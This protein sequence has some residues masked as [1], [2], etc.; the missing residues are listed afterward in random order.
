MVF[1][2]LAIGKLRDTAIRAA[3]DDYLGRARRYFRMEV[4][5]VTG[6]PRGTSPAERRRAEAAALLAGLSPD[7]TT[8]ALTRAGRSEDSAR[9][10]R[11]MATWQQ[12]GRDVTFLIGGAFGLD[13][14]VLARCDARISLSALT[15]PHE[16]ARLVL[17]EQLYRAA[18]ILNGEPYHKGSA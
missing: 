17:L 11:R 7:G 14:T 3:C 12:A 10:A 2:V 4:R 9:F 13:P 18:T 6:R 8:V 5:E 1:R 15:L 16:L